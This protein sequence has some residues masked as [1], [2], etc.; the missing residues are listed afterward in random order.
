MIR[1]LR[2]LG[3]GLALV[4][5][6]AGSASAQGVQTGTLRGTVTDPSGKGVAAVEVILSS[7]DLQERMTTATDANGRYV[8]TRLPAGTYTA[9]FRAR[10]SELTKRQVDVPLGGETAIDVRLQLTTQEARVVVVAPEV[11][12][13]IVGTNLK[14]KEV[15]DL[16]ML[17]TPTSIG[18]FAPGVSDAVM[19]PGPTEGQGQMIM[20]GSFGYDNVIMANGV[21]IG[22]NIFGWP[23]NLFIE[24]AI[25]ETHILIAGIPAEYGRFGGGVMNA[26]TKSG[27]DN[28]SG[29]YRLN[30]SNDA[31]ATETPFEVSNNRTRVS[32]TNFVHEAT[33]GGP[34]VKERLWFFVAARLSRQETTPTL[35]VS[36][37]PYETTDRNMRGEAKVTATLAPGHRVQGSI[38]GNPRHQTNQANF[39]GTAFSTIDPFALSDKDRP[40]HLI[41]VNYQGTVR[42]QL[43]IDAQYS[44]QQ[45]QTD[46][47]G[48]TSSVLKDSPFVNLN[49]T[50]QYN[51]PWFDVSDPDQRN[52]RQI[53]GSASYFRGGHEI[54]VGAEYFRSQ[55]IGGNSPSSTGY[56]FQT[57]YVADASG[58]PILDGA[59][60]IQPIFEPGDT[61]VMRFDPTKGATLNID[62]TSV[63]AQD[64]WLISNRW[65]ADIG[66]RFEYVA[67]DATGAS[68][69]LSA[70]RIVPRL[71][72]A[73]DTGGN[74]KYIVRGT[75]SRYSGRYSDALFVANSAVGNANE[76][77]GVYIGTPGVG[78]DHTAGFNLSLYD[79]D[80]VFALYP[81][82]NVQFDPDLASP[83]TT[84]FTAS[85]AADIQRRGSM[86]ATYI[87]RHMSGLVED[88]IDLDQGTTHVVD[89]GV[90]LTLTNRLYTNTDEDRR[91]YQA[92]ILQGRYTLRPQ[93]VVNGNLTVQ[94]KNEGNY[95]G[96]APSTVVTSALGDYPEIF[97]EAWH[98]PTGRLASFQRSKL[99]LWSIYNLDFGNAGSGAVSGL[100]RY[101]SARTYTLR[102]LARPTGTQLAILD[103]LDYPDAPQ[104]QALFYSK[105]GSESFAGYGIIDVSASY[106]VPVFQGV[107]PRIDID[108]YNL[109]NNQKLISWDTSIEPDPTTPRDSLGIPTGYRPRGTATGS[110]TFGT[111]TSNLNFPVPFAGGTGGR[112]FR[113]SIGVRF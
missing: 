36:G 55:K 5:C 30:F 85:F 2:R 3:L 65:S 42:Q 58:K 68:Q 67:S 18:R 108:V 70:P 32:Q 84:E 71:G 9:E 22:D 79:F 21:D 60:R 81:T 72:A 4:A 92:L 109:F 31:W 103:D 94:L 6:A 13:S 39:P 27:G 59:G 77:D 87:W 112:T 24:D 56:V 88:F 23:Q 28:W 93:W 12:T 97:T 101:N 104:S 7:P 98:Y 45:F 48:G 78:L 75:Y 37:A 19:T 35:N 86:Q 102:A 91:R 33:F 41:G 46:A 106:N 10:G 110:A 107:R 90:D 100:W 11:A 52:N 25:A 62:E 44:Q 96:E 43:L 14:Y 80:N 47:G 61:F 111:A 51:A 105:P 95:Q 74:G 63:Y 89:E 20:S 66:A 73:F 17:R 54:K 99:H 76:V 38:I 113:F 53:T 16:A 29:S 82:A 50:Q 69:G 64:H 83:V 40:N 1:H 57:D 34:V 49:F 8:F 15:D 26:T